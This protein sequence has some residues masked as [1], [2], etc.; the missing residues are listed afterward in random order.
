[1]SLT[2]HGRRYDLD[3]LRVIAFGLLIFYHVGMFYVEWGW[4]VKSAHSSQDAHWLM[5]LLNP[6]RLSLLFLISGVA[7]RFFSDKQSTL[8]VTAIRSY[9]LFIPIVFG[10]AV[11]VMPQ[12]YFE[13][14]AKGEIDMGILRFWKIYLNGPEVYSV[15]IPTWNHLWY[16][17]YLFVYGLLLAP[18]LPLMKW[19]S[20]ET[21]NSIISTL[22]RP[23]LSVLVLIPIPFLIYRF[24]LVP[25]FPT[26]HNLFSDWANHANSLSFFLLGYFIA[27]SRTFWASLD[28]VLPLAIIS[29]VVSGCVLSFIWAD[30]DN[31]STSVNDWQLNTARAGRVIYA[32]LAIASLLGLAQ[33]YLNKPSKT[34]SYLNEAVFPYYILHQTLIVTAGF[35]LTHLKLG[36]WT[37]F[38]G[39]MGSTI[40][41]CVLF[42]PII[43]NLKPIRPFFG[44]KFRR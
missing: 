8:K 19:V 39:V 28:K 41:G 18:F 17:V 4:H 43:R 24:T 1:M 31:F 25:N 26:T 33:R 9:R 29:A 20:R 36:V 13:L 42:E 16:I 3:W 30:W 2:A 40:I 27:K 32:W 35:Y 6:W 37:E 21:S 34:L 10:M 44:M 11:I 38:A 14:T 22:F 5:M 12:A 7:F 15:H 23:P